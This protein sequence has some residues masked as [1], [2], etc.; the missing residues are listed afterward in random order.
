MPVGPLVQATDGTF[1]GT[2]TAPSGTVYSLSL[3]LRPFVKPQPAAAKP[4]SIIEVLGPDL[5]GTTRVTF[6]GVAA[7]FQVMSSSF[8][9]ATVPAAATDGQIQVTT[10]AGTLASYV[11]FHVLP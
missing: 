5:T 10:P 8:L 9:V 7:G 3:G 11:P 2:T 1:Y 6:N 4:G